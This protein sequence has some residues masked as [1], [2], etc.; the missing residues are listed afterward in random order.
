MLCDQT[1]AFTRCWLN[2]CIARRMMTHI[3]AR[4]LRT[5]T[6]TSAELHPISRSR[7]RGPTGG[8]CAFSCIV[9]PCV[10]VSEVWR[11]QCLRGCRYQT[12]YLQQQR[13]SGSGL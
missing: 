5:R 3:T 12:A 4:P 9:K 7:S 8:G 6:A 11:K 2:A 1:L 10:S 13:A